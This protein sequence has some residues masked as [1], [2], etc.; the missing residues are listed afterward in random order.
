MSVAE[1]I[2]AG[3]VL[4]PIVYVVVVVIAKLGAGPFASDAQARDDSF[5]STARVPETV[6]LRAGE[7]VE[8][9]TDPKR[10]RWKYHALV[11]VLTLPFG[12]GIPT[13]VY[14]FRVR[15]RSQYIV[16]DRRIIEASPD[17]VASYDYED[18]SQVQT[19][20]RVL[21]SL[22]NRGNV[23]FNVDNRQLIT[24]GWM[25]KPDDL[26]GLLEKHTS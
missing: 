3:I 15:K 19:G 8:Y 1:I 21:E 2:G 13:L 7:T 25:E 18:I 20:A 22:L 14:A 11:G 16:T 23:Q 17:G 6:S 24:L 4:V 12:W 10:N 9:Q 26:G 5:G